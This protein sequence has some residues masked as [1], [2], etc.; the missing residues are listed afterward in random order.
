MKRLLIGVLAVLVICVVGAVVFRRGLVLAFMERQAARN[1]GTS[2]A[3]DLPDGLHVVL[4]GAGSPLPDPARSGPCVAVIAG[5]KLFVV[6]SGGGSSKTLGRTGLRHGDVD[7]I[8]LTHFHS[9]HIDGLGELLL[10]RWVNGGH[11]E[12]VPIHGPNGV[13]EVVAGLDR[14]YAQDRGYRVAHHGADVLPPSGAGARAVPFQ[15]PPMGEAVTVLQDGDLT[16]QAFTVE[17]EPIDPAVGY[18]FDY[19][20]RSVVLS[21]DTKKSANVVRF[22]KDVDLLVHEALAPQLVEVLT[23]AAKRAERPNLEKI[24]VDIMDY[25]ASPVEA[26]EVAREAGAGALLFYHIVPPLLI[27]QLETIFLEGVAEAYPGPVVIG[28]DGTRVQLP[29]GS[30]AIEFDEVL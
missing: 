7:A 2:L 28:A 1:M 29:A 4:C 6:D 10:Q 13:E 17:H 18:R 9:D 3:D 19:R 14:A 11:R 8:F 23:N 15:P 26:A 20:G 21:G 16:V 12:P 27:A 24:T 30:E 22:A 5:D 25:H